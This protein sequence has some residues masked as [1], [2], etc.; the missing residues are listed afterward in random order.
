MVE[1][2]FSF[3]ICKNQIFFSM[4]NHARFSIFSESMYAKYFQKYWHFFYVFVI[5]EMK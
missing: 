1:S 4:E 2:Y 5:C 3:K